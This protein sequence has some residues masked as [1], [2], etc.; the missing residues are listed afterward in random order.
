MDK[1]FNRPKRNYNRRYPADYGFIRTFYITL[2]LYFI[3]WPAAKIFYTAK[4]TG[5]DNIDRKAKRYIYTS[6]HQSYIDPPLLSFVAN[7]PVAYMAK[8]ELFNHKNP[9]I[10]F[11][12]ISLGAFA[13][14]R[15]KPER[16]TLKTIHDIVHKTNWQLGMFPQ[17]KTI[18]EGDLFGDIKPGFVSLAKLA[19]MDIVPVAICG[20]TGYTLMPFS[21]HLVLKI[22]KPIS[23]DLPEE[24]II[25]QWVDYMKDNVE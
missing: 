24:E 10:R 1:L 8:E 21:K 17:G 3:V 19:K 23:Y 18:R 20:F 12:V 4:V 11:L 6:N 25:K 14:N 7:R 13:V 9:L 2:F 22:G 5:W 16:A 15:D